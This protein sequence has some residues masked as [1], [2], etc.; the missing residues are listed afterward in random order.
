MSLVSTGLPPLN[1]L[2]TSV[3]LLQMYK[4][5]PGASTLSHWVIAEGD[6]RE[7]GHSI[8]DPSEYLACIIGIKKI[9]LAPVYI[10]V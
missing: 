6:A 2:A 9:Y 4:T 8:S 5:W 1:V 7:V 10:K 3:T